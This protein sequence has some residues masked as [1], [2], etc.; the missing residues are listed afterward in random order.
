MMYLRFD[1]ALP[2]QYV[3]LNDSLKP[4]SPRGPGWGRGCRQW[5]HKEMQRLNEAFSVQLA[6]ISITCGPHGQGICCITTRRQIGG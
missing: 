6:G 4:M 5:A 2:M 1:L 3:L